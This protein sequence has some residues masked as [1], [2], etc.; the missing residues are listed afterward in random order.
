MNP[1]H[2]QTRASLILRLQDAEDTAA[3][4]EFAT[5]YGPVVFNVAASRG[6]QAADADNL[7]Q[8]V[9]MAVASSISAW[10]GRDGRFGPFWIV[11]LEL[12]AG[13]RFGPV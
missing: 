7:V 8:G 11:L 12:G 10:L 9:F 6:F 5:I 13:G 1:N 4:D 3:W 2:E